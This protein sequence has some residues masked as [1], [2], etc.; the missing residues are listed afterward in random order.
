MQAPPRARARIIRAL[1]NQQP[2][3]VESWM[4]GLSEEWRARVAAAIARP[5]AGGN[6]SDEEP[7]AVEQEE[8]SRAAAPAGAEPAAVEQPAARPPA[9]AQPAAVEQ[10]AAR[11]PAQAQPAAV[12][13]PDARPPAQA[14]PAVVEQ[15]DARP[16]AQQSSAEGPRPIG[17]EVLDQGAWS[18]CSAH[19]CAAAASSALAAKCGVWVDARRLAD[20]FM[21]RGCLSAQW[22]GH[23]LARVGTLRL[24]G[25]ERVFTCLFAARATSSFSEGRVPTH[26]LLALRWDAAETGIRCIDSHGEAAP[27]PL[28]RETDFERAYF[29]VAHISDCAVPGQ[30]GKEMPAPAPPVLAD[31]ARLT[32][33][34]PGARD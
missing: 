22:P 8:A 20:Q 26:S 14:Q 2:S 32:P 13:Q 29:V 9:Q 31:W 1:R 6:S 21:D 18:S 23:L 16:P 15:P 24:L 28:V 25:R 4:G 19:A 34:W 7:A 17:N 5:P 10:P 27:Y 3:K 30:K 33:R 12:E 11:S